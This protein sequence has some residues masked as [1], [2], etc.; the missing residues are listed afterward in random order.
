MNVRRF[1]VCCVAAV[2][3]LF[4]LPIVRL[5][6]H[7]RIVIVAG[8]SSYKQTRNS[9]HFYVFLAPSQV[10]CYFGLSFLDRYC[11]RSPAFVVELIKGRAAIVF[12]R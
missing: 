10:A 7:L 5:L 2:V 9:R 1:G 3:L 8:I 6:Q 4:L 11:R 12:H